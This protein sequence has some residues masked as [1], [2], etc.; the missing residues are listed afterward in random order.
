MKKIDKS[1]KSFLVGVLVCFLG[2]GFGVSWKKA[3]GAAAWNTYDSNKELNI[4]SKYYFFVVV[5][6]NFAENDSR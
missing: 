1:G 3:F 6:H 2:T 4:L 5:P